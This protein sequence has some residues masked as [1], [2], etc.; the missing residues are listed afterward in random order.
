MPLRLLLA[1]LLAMAGCSSDERGTEPP[2]DGWANNAPTR[3]DAVVNRKT[4]QL[5]AVSQGE[6]RTWVQVP[7]VGATVG[8]YVLLGQGAV[9]HDVS[10]P[11]T[12]EQVRELVEISHVRVV[13]LET[14][15]QA[16][17]A[18]SPA[19]AVPIETV[20]AELEERADAEV[21]VVGTVRKAPH[22]V[23]WYWVHLQDGTGDAT[24]GTH[25]LTVKTQ[26]AVTVGQRVAFRGVLRSE[27]DLGFG[28]HYA[29]LVEDG[30]LL[31]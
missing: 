4:V 1:G 5:L 28:Y 15:M 24:A 23:G 30:A 19:D 16:I 10:V 14:A 13:D 20:Y 22:A 25:D 6:A 18:V 8:D 12:G 27:V 29:A 21:V 9:R 17:R 2:P 11:E 31:Q 3:V 7:A 26:Q